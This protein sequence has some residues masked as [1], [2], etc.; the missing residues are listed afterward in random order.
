MGLH[1]LPATSCWPGLL[2]TEC[3]QH[4]AI[5]AGVTL[6]QMGA[7]PRQCISVAQSR[8]EDV[9]GSLKSVPGMRPGTRPSRTVGHAS[10]L[11]LCCLAVSRRDET[12]LVTPIVAV[13]KGAAGGVRCARAISGIICVV[14]LT[15]GASDGFYRTSSQPSDESWYLHV[16]GDS[17]ASR[18]ATSLR[19]VLMPAIARCWLHISSRQARCK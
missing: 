7:H 19:E 12:A 11:I 14:S 8:G 15:G 10:S 4:S 1:A 13:S 18:I 3:S 16:N 9:C 5:V 17:S 2:W 6:L